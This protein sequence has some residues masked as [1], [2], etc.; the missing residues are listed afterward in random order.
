MGRVGVELTMSLDG[1]IAGP[2]DGPAHPLG[3]GGEA[4][5]TWFDAGDTDFV[6]P[7][8]TMTFKVA[9]A[10]AA[11]FKQTWPSYGALVSGRRTF[12]I[13][14]GWGGRHPLDVPIFVLS[15]QPR[16]AWSARL[17]NITWVMD[18]LPSA[19][20]QAQAA[21]GGKNV[22]VNAASLAQ[23]ALKAGLLDDIQIDLVPLMLGGGVRFWEDIGGKPVSLEQLEP[24]VGTGVTHLRYRVLK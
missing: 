21:A 12:D 13:A 16:P 19:I 4:L 14:Q 8:G 11:L 3:E 18:G 15:H 6:V 23:Q 9:R 7:S 10:S 5:F 24:V 22:S 2:N 20:A 17:P 1:F